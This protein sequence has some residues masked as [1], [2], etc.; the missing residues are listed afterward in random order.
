MYGETKQRTQK[1]DR[2]LEINAR[3]LAG[4]IV[5]I[6]DLAVKF[7]VDFRSI[8]RNIA[9]LRIVYSNQVITGNS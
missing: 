9:S 3:L 5:H 6:P 4:E 2:L 8:T 1:H 7:G